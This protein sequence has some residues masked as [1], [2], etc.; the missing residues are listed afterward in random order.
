M[1]TFPFLIFFR[2]S[3]ASICLLHAALFNQLGITNL[4]LAFDGDHVSELYL[5]LVFMPE[6]QSG[7]AE[8]EKWGEEER[9]KHWEGCLKQC[10]HL[11]ASPT[12][13]SGCWYLYVGDNPC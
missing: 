1:S 5:S 4:G 11:P 12:E 2:C 3:A 9:E 10:F 6:F 13:M 7:V 8:K